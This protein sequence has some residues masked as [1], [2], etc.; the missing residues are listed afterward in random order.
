MNRVGLKIVEVEGLHKALA[1]VRHYTETVA[2]GQDKMM[3]LRGVL[4]RFD[5]QNY[6]TLIFC[7]SVTS[8]QAV[9]YSLNE[10]GIESIS[11]HGDLNSRMRE[12]NLQAFRGG[13]AQY[14][15]CT[16]IAARG[17]DV[18]EIE[19]VVMFDFPLNPVDYLHRAGR[20]GRAGRSGLVTSM[21]TKRDK[22]LSE[23]IRNAISRGLPLDSLTSNK[24]DYGIG[25]HL[26]HV[27]KGPRELSA[28]V[29]SWV[30]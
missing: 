25:G 27:V 1:N 2:G 12:A 24:K 26:S 7:N 30:F 5:L 3:V 4:S 14:L 28:E 20:C 13:Q 16:D 11:Y 17:L 19:H 8:C 15:V 21:V 9:A 23:G 29:C 22:V 6:R 10:V 18:P